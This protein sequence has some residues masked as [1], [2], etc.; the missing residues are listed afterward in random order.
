MTDQEDSE[1][2]SADL[3]GSSDVGRIGNCG[4]RS[5][6]GEINFK[7]HSDQSGNVSIER[8]NYEDEVLT[9]IGILLDYNN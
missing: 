4:D 7:D 2:E 3:T 6:C 9:E 8:K 5:N 1:Y